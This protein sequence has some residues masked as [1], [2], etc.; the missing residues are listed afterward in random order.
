MHFAR[1]IQNNLEW[2]CY[3]GASPFLMAF[4]ACAGPSP[5]VY[6][7][8]AFSRRALS[9]K[10]GLIVS[11]EVTSENHAFHRAKSSLS[12]RKSSIA[13]PRNALSGID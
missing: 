11:F 4:N 13:T 7:L 12:V 8:Y 2:G 3:G 9:A 10:I 5:V 1:V 6:I